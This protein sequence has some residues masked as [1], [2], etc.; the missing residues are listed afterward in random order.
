MT[1]RADAVR[2]ACGTDTTYE[3]RRVLV[4]LA[5]GVDDNMIG[6]WPSLADMVDVARTDVGELPG[7]IRSLHAG[8][9]LTYAG[10]NYRLTPRAEVSR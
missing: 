4:A 9:Y 10:R 6:R 3:Q 2:W 8:G 7:I 1:A 5:L